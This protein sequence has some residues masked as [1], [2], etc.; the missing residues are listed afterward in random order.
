MHSRL[1]RSLLVMF[2]GRP[3][4]FF[5]RHSRVKDP[6]VQRNGSNTAQA[7]A[8]AQSETTRSGGVWES[9]VQDCVS[10]AREAIDMCHIMRTGSIGLAR[11]SYIEYSSCRASLLVLIAYSI[12][13]RTN[14]FSSTLRCGLNAIKEMATVGDS[15]RSEVSLLE[16][17]EAALQRLRVFGSRPTQALATAGNDVMQESYEGFVDWCKNQTASSNSRAGRAEKVGNNTKEVVGQCPENDALAN[18]HKTVISP[19]VDALPADWSFDLDFY[20]TDEN[21]ALFTPDFGEYGLPEGLIDSLL[22]VPD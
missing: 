7:P 19:P 1:D 10:A 3:F 9:L 8:D 12:C 14:E 2:I 5:Y 18:S 16:T 6:I 15:A 21:M 22:S 11:S 4:I 17:L 20:N 13:Y